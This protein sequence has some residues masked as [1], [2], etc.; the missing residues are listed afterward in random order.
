MPP[1]ERSKT[2]ARRFISEMQI[3][4]YCFSGVI[5]VYVRLALVGHL[6]AV[7]SAAHTTETELWSFSVSGLAL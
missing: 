2:L 4:E 3:L 7:L 1:P 6:L 5:A